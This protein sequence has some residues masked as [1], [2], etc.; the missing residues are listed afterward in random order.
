VNHVFY[1]LGM[2]RLFCII[3]FLAWLL[4]SCGGSQSQDELPNI[5]LI[6]ADDMGSGD[7]QAY[8]PDSKIPTPYLNRMASEG[9]RFTDA[10]SPSA[11]CTPTRYGLLTGRYSWRTRLK[12]GVLWGYSPSLIEEGRSTIASVLKER[13]YTTLGVGKWHLGLGSAE[14]VDYSQ[15]LNPSPVSFG[16]DYYFG[17]PASLDMD[18]YLYIENDRAFQEPTNSV[19]ASQHRR[20]EGGGFWR[21]GPTAPDF[22]HVDVLPELA[23]RAV[24]AVKT[25]GERDQ[26][27][28]FFLYF[29]LT[30]PHTPWLPLPE[31]QGKSKAG[32]YG[33]FCAQVDSVVGEVVRAVGESAKRNTLI[34][35]TSD[36]GAHW[37]VS[38]IER[39]GH[40]ANLGFR[41]QK[42]DIWE[43]GHRVPL[44]AQWKGHT[45]AGTTVESLVS[46]T[47]VFATVAEIAGIRLK[48]SQGEDSRSFLSILRGGLSPGNQRTEMVHH[49]VDGMFA[50]RQ[51]QWKL[52]LGRGSGGFTDPTRVEVEPGEPEGQLYDLTE[53]PSE[54]ENLYLQK[55][56]IV[57]R[58]SM[59]LEDTIAQAGNRFSDSN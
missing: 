45:P 59:A 23:R 29:A 53:D 50:I 6:L 18:P 9:I 40:R 28:P 24:R 32:Y 3:V 15:P 8:N 34:L 44:I 46:L 52:I 41:G 11:V 10:H 25:H 43:G 13:G 7:I 39:W 27:A 5:V 47:D 26:V 56:D 51:G 57:D 21:A 2:S 37:P 22:R 33:D 35:F 36:N 55:P 42:A 12:K 38:D 30:A 48:A 31:F 54:Q 19:E 1:D 4:V 58:M 17:I 20:E 14:K 49:S 16:F